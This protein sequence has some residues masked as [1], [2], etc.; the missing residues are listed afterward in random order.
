MEKNIFEKCLYRS[1]MYCMVA[2]VLIG[3]GIGIFVKKVFCL[4]DTTSSNFG[5]YIIICS[6]ILA[7]W[8][9]I[10]YKKITNKDIMR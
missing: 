3:F 7:M 4:S 10:V 6:S 8:P 2:Y 9:C 1:C 5:M